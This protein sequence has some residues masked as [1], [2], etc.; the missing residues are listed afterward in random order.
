MLH[1]CRYIHRNPLD[2]GLVKDLDE[3]L[4]TNYLEWVGKRPG[5]LVDLE[6][7]HAFFPE[8]GK[9]TQFVLE[10]TPPP[11]TVEVVHKLALD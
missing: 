10:Y 1:L 4:Y 5:S 8:P 3:W 6:F 11:K 2:A 9:Y 7:V